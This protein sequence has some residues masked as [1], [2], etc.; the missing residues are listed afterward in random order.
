MWIDLKQKK[1][2]FFKYFEVVPPYKA[3][4][5]KEQV[6]VTPTIKLGVTVTLAT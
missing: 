2:I 3:P 6:I 1:K 5:R 4:I